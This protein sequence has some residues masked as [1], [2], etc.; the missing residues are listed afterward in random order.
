MKPS[1]TVIGRLT[2]DVT[3]IFS[4]D[5]GTAKRALFTVACNSVYKRDNEK[6][7]TV[8]FVPCIAW[9]PQADLLQKWGLKGRHVAIRG[10]I[11]T[12]QKPADADGNYE[13]TKVQVRVGQI[14]FL[15]FEDNVREKFEAEKVGVV[16]GAAG[17]EALAAAL[18]GI[19]NGMKPKPAAVSPPKPKP[20]TGNAALIAELLGAM[21]KPKEEVKPEPEPL[22]GK[23][24]LIEQLLAAVNA[25][26]LEKPA[27]QVVE[28]PNEVANQELIDELASLV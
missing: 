11:E 12:F 25:G 3:S 15:G 19:I 27:E 17:P 10:T 4:N 13:P 23:E 22:V 8:D 14:E 28:E 2:R 7:K 18:L 16:A 21:N 6:V 1:A 5:D 20:A 9:G 26:K 24:S